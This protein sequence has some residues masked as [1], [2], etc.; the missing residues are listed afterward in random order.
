MTGMRF[1][2][3]LSCLLLPAILAG[4]SIFPWGDD[5]DSAQTADS[6][7]VEH[8]TG[9]SSR[10]RTPQPTSLRV[11]VPLGPLM[12]FHVAHGSSITRLVPATSFQREVLMGPRPVNSPRMRFPVRHDL[13]RSVRIDKTKVL[14]SSAVGTVATGIDKIKPN[15]GKKDNSNGEDEGDSSP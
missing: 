13:R 15:F 14:G 10:V 3:A 7:P 6:S 12:S 2:P 11:L 4:C 1:F 8:Q 9:K 5:S